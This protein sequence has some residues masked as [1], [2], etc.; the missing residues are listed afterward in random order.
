[1]GPQAPFLQVDVDS[2][3]CAEVYDSLA[4]WAEEVDFTLHP[5]GGLLYKDK[6]KGYASLLKPLDKLLLL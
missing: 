4:S 1:M 5:I 6:E 2:N 3:S